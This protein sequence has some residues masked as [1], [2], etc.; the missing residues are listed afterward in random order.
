[1]HFFKFKINSYSALDDEKNEENE[2]LQEELNT[3][4]KGKNKWINKTKINI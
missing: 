2:K 4:R 3:T 1:M